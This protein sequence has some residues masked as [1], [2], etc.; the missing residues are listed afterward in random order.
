MI[1]LIWISCTLKRPPI[2]KFDTHDESGHPYES[3]TH[4]QEVC[5]LRATVVKN[6]KVSVATYSVGRF[7]ELVQ[8]SEL[9]EASER[10]LVFSTFRD[11]A[12]H[13]LI[14]A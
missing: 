7:V 11:S 3:K 14:N 10:V 4:I 9:E 8:F 5:P 13:K 12:K 2:K 6:T 1:G